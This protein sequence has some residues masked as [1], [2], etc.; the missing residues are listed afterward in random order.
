VSHEL[1]PA[2]QPGPLAA[3]RRPTVSRR[4]TPNLTNKG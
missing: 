2:R 4:N 1:R 3:D